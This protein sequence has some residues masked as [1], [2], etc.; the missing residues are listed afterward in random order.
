MKRLLPFLAVMACDYQLPDE[1]VA[2]P[3]SA[4]AVAAAIRY[5]I[6]TRELEADYHVTVIT[7]DEMLTESLE[8]HIVRTA[9]RSAR[10][11]ELSGEIMNVEGTPLALSRCSFPA[12]LVELTPVAEEQSDGSYHVSIEEVARTGLVTAEGH[13]LEEQ[14]GF[15]SYKL[16]VRWDGKRWNVELD[17]NWGTET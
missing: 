9:T 2:E 4:S 15:I 13:W 12:D 14:P 6:E 17:E 10:E 3:S 1:P 8:D 5:A 7:S 11:C 16:V